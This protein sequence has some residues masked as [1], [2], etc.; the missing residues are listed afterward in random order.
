MA[1]QQQAIGSQVK[2][3]CLGDIVDEI[4]NGRFLSYA[5]FVR[6]T[7]LLLFRVALLGF[8]L[9]LL[10]IMA[11]LL[12]AS[13]LAMGGQIRLFQATALV[14]LATTI[15]VVAIKAWTSS[16]EWKFK[17]GRILRDWVPFLFIVFIYENLHDV[18]GQVTDLDIAGVLL[19]WDEVM[20][21]IEPTIW[22]QKI[23]TPLRTDLFSISYA[24]YF[25]E[26]LFIM[27]LLSLKERSRDFRHMA[28][29]LTITFILGFLGYIFLPA[30]PPRYFIE[31]LYDNPPRLFGLFLFNRLQ[32]AWDSLSVVS[33][34]AFPSLHVG[35]S[36][37]ALIYAF[38][39]RKC[40]AMFR[41]IWWAYIPLVTSLW[42]STIYLRHHWV[43]DI[44]AGWGVALLGFGGSEIL[45]RI[46][47]RL[48]RRYGLLR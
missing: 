36:S 31:H 20:F 1:T 15:A 22:A 9:V 41:V 11:V 39:Y 28:L 6:L 32:G 25:L 8:D 2:T 19:R 17:V 4:K 48:Q 44:F 45:C 35:L 27:F 34:G 21:G 43:I 37:V 23:F 46:W 7:D 24:L 47:E 3:P 18:A 16:G 30:S 14:P 10:I 33:G 42:F 13:V 26:P 29:A 38:R 5:A 40:G 12:M